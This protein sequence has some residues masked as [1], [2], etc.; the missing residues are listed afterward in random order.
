MFKKAAALPTIRS[1]SGRRIMDG[2]QGGSLQHDLSEDVP[3]SGQRCLKHVPETG[4]P[5]S[6]APNAS[7]QSPLRVCKWNLAE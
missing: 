4:W 2:G 5:K 1:S 7:V 3:A 6:H